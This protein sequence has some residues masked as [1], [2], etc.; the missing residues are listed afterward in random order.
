MPTLEEIQQQIDNLPHKYIFYTKKEIK[1]LPEIM[2]DGEYIRALVSGYM[3]KRT[4][5]AVCTN[6]RVLLLDKGFFFGM[7]Q[8]QLALDRIQSINGDYLIGFGNIR[9]WDG[10][11]AM[12]LSMVWAS[13]IDPFIKEVRQAIDDYRHLNFQEITSSRQQQM[14]QQAAPQQAAV[15]PAAAQPAA[16]PVD[17]ASQLER[18][19]ALREAGHLTEEEFQYQKHKIISG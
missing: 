6:R 2:M 9:L 13:N 11:S 7:R 4:V 18:L 12:T 14:A 8:W 1:M 5:L 10:A 17:V 19:A 16:A 3:G 15:A